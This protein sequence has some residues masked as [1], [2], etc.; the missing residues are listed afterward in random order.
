MV[1]DG[2]LTRGRAGHV[3]FEACQEREGGGRYP[4][5]VQLFTVVR[6]RLDAP[7]G[8]G[9]VLAGN[10]SGLTRVEADEPWVPL[11][12]LTNELRAAIA[13]I[14]TRG[15]VSA[16]DQTVSVR[17]PMPAHGALVDWLVPRAM[18]VA[19]LLRSAALAIPPTRALGAARELLRGIADKR[20][21]RFEQEHLT[22]H[23]QQLGFPVTAG[24]R[25]GNLGR[26]VARIELRFPTPL[27]TEIT[28]KTEKR[29]AFGRLL[30]FGD[31]EV[32]NE[33]F[34]GNF[35]VYADKH[36]VGETLGPEVQQA[37]VR[38]G[39]LA[40]VE[41]RPAGIDVD[42]GDRD[43]A[44]LLNE[45]IDRTGEVADLVARARAAGPAAGPYR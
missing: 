9:L 43:P 33:L 11:A 7:L 24:L 21:W 25:R 28:V 34:D 37:L 3:S 38:L 30:T 1:R 20:G 2:I 6:A 35:V 29:D 8:L 36:A 27:P 32:G 17:A 42:M 15:S 45:V 44:P 12:L 39:A 14:A 16:D 18:G 31:R 10:A 22:V 4:D 19:E 41:M 5:R 40:E 23:G 13:A 26:F